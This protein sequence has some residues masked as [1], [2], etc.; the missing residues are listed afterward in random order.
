MI[1]DLKA[2]FDRLPRDQLFKKLDRLP[3]SAYLLD[4]IKELYNITP[5]SI[6]DSTFF[7]TMGVKQGCGLSPIIF[8]L[9]MWDLERTLI[10]AQTG[11]VVINK[12]RVHSLAYA[13]DIVLLTDSTNDLRE[14]IRLT[15]KYLTRNGLTIN[16]DKTK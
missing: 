9:Y 1:V 4:H 6:G 3:I 15:D 5:I 10:R 14:I 8:A 13:D 2:L 11:G 16:A 12:V 7:K